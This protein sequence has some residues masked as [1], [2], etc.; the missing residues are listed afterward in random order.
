M[1]KYGCNKKYS[2]VRNMSEIVLVSQWD[3][4]SKF[5]SLYY[6]TILK[7]V[8]GVQRSGHAQGTIICLFGPLFFS[9]NGITLKKLTKIIKIQ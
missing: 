5:I 1:N 8:L 6:Y 7:D 4:L 3:F 2:L 9:Q